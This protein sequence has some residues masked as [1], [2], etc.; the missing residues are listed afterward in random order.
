MGARF[1]LFK[2]VDR[3]CVPTRMH[4]LIGGTTHVA[5]NHQSEG[6][7]SEPHVLCITINYIVY[8]VLNDLYTNV[9]MWMDESRPA[10][11]LSRMVDIGQLPIW[12]I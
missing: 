9:H 1:N 10:H 6:I 8:G 12:F 11:D 5:H 2:A 3:S 4:Q 7:K